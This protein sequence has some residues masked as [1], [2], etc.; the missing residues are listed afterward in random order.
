VKATEIFTAGAS[1]GGYDS[2]PV[3]GRLLLLG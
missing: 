3:T 1:H 2:R